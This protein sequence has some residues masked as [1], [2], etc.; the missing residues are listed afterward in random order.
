[1]SGAALAEPGE[2]LPPPLPPAPPRAEA[3]QISVAPTL[4]YL[5]LAKAYRS[6]QRLHQYRYRV[7]PE[8]VRQLE[9]AIDLTQAEAAVLADRLRHY[10]QFATFGNDSSAYTGAQDTRLA[11]LAV[12]QRL[13]RLERARDG[14]SRERRSTLLL[15]QLEHLELLEELRQQQAR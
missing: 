4:S 10:R 9:D 3:P 7:Y 12:D 8:Q 14:L 2:P 11:L 1:M 15:L 5:Q 13:R 6:A